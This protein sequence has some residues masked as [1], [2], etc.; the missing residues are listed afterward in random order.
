MNLEEFIAST[1]FPDGSHPEKIKIIGWYLHTYKSA[2]RFDIASVRSCYQKLHYEPPNLS[3]DFER[4]CD[5]QPKELIKDGGGYRLEARTRAHF[6]GK[7]GQSQSSIAITKL[8]SELPA[9]IPSVAEREFLS[10]ALS[11]YKVKAFRACVVMSWNLAF[12]HLTNWLLKDSQRLAVYN[13]GISKRFPK[14]NLSIT[15]LLDFEELKEREVIE[16]LNSSGLVSSNI[17]KILLKDLDR[18]NSAAHPSVVNISQH[19]AEDTI[20]DLINNVVLQLV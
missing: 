18:R 20:S 10:E 6:D 16:A 19:Q 7:F 3:R 4:L 13:S 9:K 5:R 15:R 8:L 11:C 1:N 2:D 12:N 17:I 14:K